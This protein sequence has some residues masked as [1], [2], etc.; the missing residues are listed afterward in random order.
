MN[1][2]DTVA[3]GF[4]DTSGNPAPP[5]QNYSIAW[6]G[7][8]SFTVACPNLLTGTYSQNTNVITV[9][10]NANGLAPG[11][12]AELVFTTG[13]AANGLYLVAGTNSANSFTISTPDSAVRSGSCLLPKIAASGLVQAGTNVTISCAAPHGHDT[14]ETLYIIFNSNLPVDGQ[15]QV[16]G[17][18]DATHFT[19]VATNSTQP[20]PERLQ[21]PYP[22]GPPVLGLRSGI[23]TVQW[24]TW[25]PWARP[26]TARPTT[27]LR[28][29]VELEHGL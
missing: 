29:A 4:T 14:K 15:Y 10:I 3:I 13:G 25:E 6:T 27:S 8:N 26:T 21:H 1:S 22:L 11:N 18:P 20:D 16:K 23:A 17:I 5:S 9:N 7:S 24:N 2:G 19:V 28:V 12:A